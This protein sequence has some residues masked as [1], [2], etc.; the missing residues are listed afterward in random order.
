MKIYT[1]IRPDPEGKPT[2]RVEPHYE[3][4]DTPTI[5]N[6]GL[7]LVKALEGGDGSPSEEDKLLEE[8]QKLK[9]ALQQ[10]MGLDFRSCPSVDTRRVAQNEYIIRGPWKE[11]G[12]LLDCYGACRKVQ[13][14]TRHGKH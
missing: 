10:V 13:E 7:A 5:Q 1:W 12:F 4:R 2:M 6:Y 8:N 9:A 3:S 11:I 14:A